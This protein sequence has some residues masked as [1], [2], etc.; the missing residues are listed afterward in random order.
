[1][2]TT[3]TIEAPRQPDVLELMRAADEYALSL[4]PPEAYHKLDVADLERPGVT[5][6]VA[7]DDGL[8]GIVALVENGDGSAEVKRM[9]VAETHRG[10]GVAGALLGR[11]AEAAAAASVSVIRLETGWE[12]P[13]A[14]ALYLKHGYV[15]IP[16]F[17]KYVGDESS[18][19]MEKRLA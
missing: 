4:Y 9:F 7:R 19:C 8:A 18:V 15:H 17:G 16:N 2:P 10:R 14:I 5:L 12:Q 13:D 1:M 6:F 3:I 11:L